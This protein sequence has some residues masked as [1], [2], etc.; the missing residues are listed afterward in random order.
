MQLNPD[1]LGDFANAAFLGTA[2]SLA[3]LPAD[4]G[5]SE[6]QSQLGLDAQLISVDNTQAYIGKNEEHV[7]VAFRGSE[8]PTMVDG[9]K[10]WLLTNA[11]NYLVLPEGD[12]GTDFVAAG[13]G[14]RFHSGFMSALA[15]IWDALYEPTKAAVEEN[16]RYLWV[17]GHSLGGA[18]ALLAAWRLKRKYLDVHAVYTFGAPMIGNAATAEAFGREFP[19]RIYRFV[20]AGDLVPLLPTVSLTANEYSHCLKEMPVGAVAEAALA[21]IQALAQGATDGV[22]SLTIMEDLWAKLQGAV[23]AHLM[24]NYLNGIKEKS[25]QA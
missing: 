10:D 9:L 3:Y 2:A 16:D 4:E 1:A 14:C 19:D 7:V 8:S 6:Y 23:D 17:T 12:L 24:P 5:K 13:V 20:D 15:E 11:R 21:K 25:G 18:I 22:L